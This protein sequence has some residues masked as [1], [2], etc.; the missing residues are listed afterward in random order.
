[1]NV[2][3]KDVIYLKTVYGT[4]GHTHRL[5]YSWLERQ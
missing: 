1:M 3:K 4:V 5:V 2:D